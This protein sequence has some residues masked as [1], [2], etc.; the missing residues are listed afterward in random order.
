M[1]RYREGGFQLGSFFRQQLVVL[2]VFWLTV[3]APMTCEYHGLLLFS[4]PT[5][6][7]TAHLE[8]ADHLGSV[9][10]GGHQLRNHEMA[11]SVTL[12]PSLFLM[13]LPLTLIIQLPEQGHPFGPP[14]PTP[15]R[16]WVL[17]PPD[18]PPRS[19]G[20]INAV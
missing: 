8:H 19:S 1:M 16:E 7:A 6:H 14:D 15:P 5:V 20:L 18:Q 3:A 10:A 11:T 13:A 12:M 4:A 9:Q 2:L 17:P